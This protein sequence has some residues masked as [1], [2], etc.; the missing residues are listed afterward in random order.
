MAALLTEKIKGRILDGSA[1]LRKVSA[2]D[3][4]AADSSVRLA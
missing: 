3:I 2:A 1:G 4:G